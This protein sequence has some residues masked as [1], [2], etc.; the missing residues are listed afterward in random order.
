M[1]RGRVHRP[2]MPQPAPRDPPAFASRA[3]RAELQ[4]QLE[5]AR[6]AGDRQRVSQL[7][8]R[9]MLTPHDRTPPGSEA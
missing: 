5:A 9:L 8:G 1:K 6:A 4:A 7:L 3:T 2:G